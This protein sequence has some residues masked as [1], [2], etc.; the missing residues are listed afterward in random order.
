MNDFSVLDIQTNTLTLVTTYKCTAACE[1]CCFGCTP[2]SEGRLTLDQILS[3]INQAK[4][5][6]PALALVVFTGGEC[7]LLKDDLFTAIKAATDLGLATRCVTN[8]FWG[9]TEHGAK[10]TAVRCAEAGL[11]EINFSTGKDHQEYVPKQSITNAAQATVAQNIFSLITIESD[12]AD[13]NAEGELLTCPIVNDL[14]AKHQDKFMIQVNAWMPFTP[15]AGTRKAPA[16]SEGPCTQLFHNVVVTPHAQISACC[17]LTYEHIPE[18]ILGALDEAPLKQTYGKQ[19]DD[20][21]KIWIRVEGPSGIARSVLPHDAAENVIN[22]CVHICQLCAVV[23]QNEEIRTAIESQWEN[24]V[25][26]ILPAF[27]AATLGACVASVVDNTVHTSV[28]SDEEQ[29]CAIEDV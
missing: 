6:F 18:M 2:Q 5:D 11:K 15:D 27:H 24:H 29:E 17:G 22:S 10:R 21:M 25:G 9:K 26:R 20:F 7:F 23:H 1:Q 14:L 3:A 16:K 12:A 8:G 28:L 13:S 4:R 19:V